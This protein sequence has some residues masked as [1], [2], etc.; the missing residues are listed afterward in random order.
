MK[1]FIVFV[2]LFIIFVGGD[3]HLNANGP[4][5]KYHAIGDEPSPH[6]CNRGTGISSSSSKMVTVTNINVSTTTYSSNEQII[7]TWTPISTPCVDDFVGVY[8]VDIDLSKGK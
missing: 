6:A 5:G 4:F 8:F 1:C 7:I 2:S 3:R